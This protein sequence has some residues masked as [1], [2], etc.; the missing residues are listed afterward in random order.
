MI[1]E[2]KV[3]I[4][5]SKVA[6]VD[7]DGKDLQIPHSDSIGDVAYIKYENDKY[8]VITKEAFEKAIA[9]KNN[10]VIKNNIGIKEPVENTASEIVID[11]EVAGV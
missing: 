2:C 4:H 8:S 9:K 3:K 10:K 7:F 11:N 6:V 1:R 5:N